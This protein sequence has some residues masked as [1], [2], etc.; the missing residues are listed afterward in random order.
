MSSKNEPD[1]LDIIRASQTLLNNITQLNTGTSGIKKTIIS[2]VGKLQQSGT[3]NPRGR[4]QIFLQDDDD[5]N[6]SKTQQQDFRTFSP[7][8]RIINPQEPSGNLNTIKRFT[9]TEISKKVTAKKI[10]DVSD[11]FEMQIIDDKLGMKLIIGGTIYHI[12]D[13]D[14]F[15]DKIFLLYPRDE[16][17]CIT[18]NKGIDWNKNKLL[19]NNHINQYLS[20]KT[21]DFKRLLQQIT[22][23]KD[24]GDQFSF[25]ETVNFDAVRKVYQLFR[26]FN[27]FKDSSLLVGYIKFLEPNIRISDTKHTI[28]NTFSNNFMPAAI[29]IK[30]LTRNKDMNFAQ[31]PMNSLFFFG[32]L[33][34]QD[35][36]KR[37]HDLHYTKLHALPLWSNNCYKWIVENIHILLND[38]PTIWQQLVKFCGDTK[39]N[40]QIFNSKLRSLLLDSRNRHISLAF[41]FIWIKL[42]Q[43]LELNKCYMKASRSLCSWITRYSELV[44]HSF[45]NLVKA[46]ESCGTI[47]FKKDKYAQVQ[48]VLKGLLR[49]IFILKQ[50]KYLLGNRLTSVQHD[51]NQT[52]ASNNKLK[53]SLQK[54]QQTVSEVTNKFNKTLKRFDNR[55]VEDDNEDNSSSKY[56]QEIKRLTALLKSRDSKIN[57]LK[58]QLS[59]SQIKAKHF[60]KEYK[61][62]LDENG[63]LNNVIGKQKVTLSKQNEEIQKYRNKLNEVDTKLSRFSQQYE[64]KLNS[65][66]KQK[67]NDY[68]QYEQQVSQYLQDIKQYKK[69]VTSL[70]NQCN[71]LQRQNDQLNIKLKNVICDRCDE[72]KNHLK[73][74]TDLLQ[75]L[76][77]QFRVYQTQTNDQIEKLKTQLVQAQTDSHLQSQSNW[78]SDPQITL[79]FDKDELISNLQ[80]DVSSL[81]DRLRSLNMFYQALYRIYLVLNAFIQQTNKNNS[82]KIQTNKQISK[83]AIDILKNNVWNIIWKTVPEHHYSLG[84][85]SLDKFKQGIMWNNVHN[86]N[87][88][89]K[90]QWSLLFP[91]SSDPYD[92]DQNRFK[93][94]T[95]MH[96]SLTFPSLFPTLSSTSKPKENLLKDENF[97]QINFNIQ[98]DSDLDLS[99]AFNEDEILNQGQK[100]PFE[101]IELK[102][103]D[104]ILI[105]P[106]KNQNRIES[107][108]HRT[109]IPDSLK[110]PSEKTKLPKLDDS[111]SDDDNNLNDLDKLIAKEKAKTD[112]D[113]LFNIGLGKDQ[114]PRREQ[115]L[116]EE[117]I[118][119]SSCPP[120]ILFSPS[121]HFSN[122]ELQIYNACAPVDYVT[123]H[124]VPAFDFNPDIPTVSLDLESH[125]LDLHTLAGNFEYQEI[126]ERVLEDAKYN[127]YGYGTK[128]HGRAH[129]FLA[130][131]FTVVTGSDVPWSKWLV[132]FGFYM[133]GNMNIWYNSKL[134]ET[135]N[136]DAQRQWYDFLYLFVQENLNENTPK[137][138]LDW[139]QHQ[140]FVGSDIF[141][142]LKLAQDA[143]YRLHILHVMVFTQFRTYFRKYKM[144]GNLEILKILINAINDKK[145][146]KHVKKSMNEIARIS[147]LNGVFEFL[148]TYYRDKQK[149][150]AVKLDYSLDYVFPTKQFYQYYFKSSREFQIKLNYQAI[151]GKDFV[152]PRLK[153]RNEWRVPYKDWQKLQ[154]LN[155]L[156]LFNNQPKIEIISGN[157]S[158]YNQQSYN[159]S[160]NWKKKSYNRNYGNNKSYNRN[161][162]WK[163]N[164]SYKKNNSNGKNQ[165]KNGKNNGNSTQQ[166]VKQD[167]QWSTNTANSN[168][169]SNN[170]NNSNKNVES[171][172]HDSSFHFRNRLTYDQPHHIHSHVFEKR[173]SKNNGRNRNKSNSKFN[174][175]NNKFNSRS[176]GRND[177]RELNKKTCNSCH[178][179]FGNHA[180]E[181]PK[182]NSNGNRPNYHKGNNNKKQ[183]NN[184]NNRSYAIHTVDINRPNPIDYF[185]EKNNIPIC[186]ICLDRH[187][188]T[189]DQKELNIKLN[190]KQIFDS[191]VLENSK[192]LNSHP[193]QILG[194]KHSIL[195]SMTIEN[196]LDSSKDKL[197]GT[198]FEKPQEVID[199]EISNLIYNPDFEYLCDNDFNLAIYRNILEYYDGEILS[200]RTLYNGTDEL[201]SESGISYT[202]GINLDSQIPK[203]SINDLENELDINLHP[204]KWLTKMIYYLQLLVTCKYAKQLYSLIISLLTLI[205]IWASKFMFN[206]SVFLTQYLISIISTIFALVS[207]LK[208]H[209][210]HK[211]IYFILLLY[212]TSLCKA[213]PAALRDNYAYLTSADPFVF[214]HAVECLSIRTV[215]TYCYIDFDK[216]ASAATDNICIANT[217]KEYT[218]KLDSGSDINIVNTYYWKKLRDYVRLGNVRYRVATA[219]GIT[220]IQNYLY[221]ELTATSGE[222]FWTKFFYAPDLNSKYGFI[223]SKQCCRLLGYEVKSSV[224]FRV[225]NEFHSDT[226]VSPA[227]WSRYDPFNTI[228]FQESWRG[229]DLHEI[230]YELI[231]SEIMFV[232]ADVKAFVREQLYL[233]W[234]L[235]GTNNRYNIARIKGFQYEFQLVENPV[236]TPVAPYQLPYSDTIDIYEQIRQLLHADMIEKVTDT[237]LHAAPTFSLRK[238]V[239]PGTPKG[240][241]SE[242]RMLHNYSQLNANILDIQDMTPNLWDCL[243]T[244][245]GHLYTSSY[246]L[247][248]AYSQLEIAE[249]CRKYVRFSVPDGS[250]YQWKVG[251]FGLKDL[252]SVWN[253]VMSNIFK[254]LGLTYY[255]DDISHGNDTIEEWQIDF[256]RFLD[257]SYEFHLT[258][259]VGKCKFC[260][261]EVQLLGHLIVKGKIHPTEEQRSKYLSIPT[262][263]GKKD[264]KRYLGVLSYCSKFISR[265]AHLSVDFYELLQKNVTFKWNLRLDKK[266]KI[267]TQA[268][269]TYQVL[270]APNYDYPFILAVDAS[271][272][273]AGCSIF[274]IYAD[275]SGERTFHFIE[276]GS[277]K[278]SQLQKNAWHSTEKEVWSV[279][280]FL[281]RYSKYFLSGKC[282]HHVYSDAE[283]LKR[284]F[285]KNQ[286]NSKMMRYRYRIAAYKIQVHHIPGELN[287]LPDFLSRHTDNLHYEQNKL[288]KLHVLN[289]IVNENIKIYE[290]ALEVQQNVYNQ[291]HIPNT[292]YSVMADTEHNPICDECHH[293]LH[294]N[295]IFNM[296]GYLNDE[297]N[298]CHKVISKSEN[299]WHCLNSSKHLNHYVI[300]EECSESKLNNWQQQ[301]YYIRNLRP[302]PYRIIHRPYINQLSFS[303]NVNIHNLELLPIEKKKRRRRKLSITLPES[304]ICP[305]KGCQHILDIGKFS[306]WYPGDGACDLCDADIQPNHTVYHCP[307]TIHY[308][309]E[310][311]DEHG[312]DI[313]VKCICKDIGMEV[314]EKYDYDMNIIPDEKSEKSEES[315][316]IEDVP[317]E[318][319]VTPSL[320]DLKLQQD[321]LIQST[322][323]KDDVKEMESKSDEKEDL[324]DISINSDPVS[325]PNIDD[326]IELHI[327][328]EEPEQSSSIGQYSKSP[329]EPKPFRPPKSSQD[330]D[331][332]DDDILT[333]SSKSNQSLVDDNIY[334]NNF[335]KTFHPF[336][337]NEF[338]RINIDVFKQ[339]QIADPIFG[340]IIQYL[341]NQRTYNSLS[342]YIKRL[343][344]N[345]TFQISNRS[346]LLTFKS[347]KNKIVRVCVPETCQATTV[348]EFHNKY[349]HLGMGKLL[350]YL[351]RK[352]YWPS[353]NK[354]IE[355]QC[356]CC[357]ICAKGKITSSPHVARF[358][359]IKPTRPNQILGMDFIGP[360]PYESEYG[361]QYILTV[362]DYFD[363]YTK[364]IPCK[365]NSAFETYLSLVNQWFFSE[366]IPEEIVVDRGSHFTASLQKTNSEMMNYSIKFT[367]SYNPRAAGLVERYNRRFRSFMRTLALDS[368]KSKH[369]FEWWQFCGVCSYINNITISKKTGLSPWQM[370]RC[371]QPLDVPHYLENI[372]KA[373]F[374]PKFAHRKYF[375]FLKKQRKLFKEVRVIGRRNWN[376]Y[377]SKRS[378][379]YFEKLT[380]RQRKLLE[381]ANLHIGRICM[382]KNVTK[383]GIVKDKLSSQYRGPFIII[384]RTVGNN[385][386]RIRNIVTDE[387]KYVNHRHIKLIDLDNDDPVLVAYKLRFPSDNRSSSENQQEDMNLHNLDGD[388]SEKK[389][390]STRKKRDKE[391]KEDDDVSLLDKQSSL[392]SLPSEK[393]KVEPSHHNENEFGD[394][395]ES[396]NDI[397]LHS[398]NY[399]SN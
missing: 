183:K 236:W 15:V 388:Y 343:L 307:A 306:K 239:P 31:F 185:P 266:W 204:T 385:A 206:K 316:I 18:F 58:K 310:N 33:S 366:G 243:Q 2:S 289:P 27:L 132:L 378:I 87:A 238:K 373:L 55:L 377:I 341:N 139:I 372:D 227:E 109:F 271:D 81:K 347:K 197:N 219:N 318:R 46:Y 220:F 367:T 135:K 176:K 370:R 371:T 311:T 100:P 247:R 303:Q 168:S 181:C 390:S 346:D 379:K 270:E 94:L 71:E 355:D 344:S 108:F 360:M 138:L 5:E 396:D 82:P 21:F 380:N 274:Q 232:N 106:D 115:K 211:F 42:Q 30:Q 352:Y 154:N 187:S 209:L 323:E 93:F 334:L 382:V 278:F 98:D 194:N 150:Y 264:L 314:P 376:K 45:N 223:L 157:K 389:R 126:K 299:A 96:K 60:D 191:D 365:N 7:I 234:E 4:T 122:E 164:N 117:P 292:L 369:D 175:R 291:I 142:F 172:S 297:C 34:S 113:L 12:N 298:K 32:G 64:N 374:E 169:N 342:P 116:I 358:Q 254:D 40:S 364:Y 86:N 308:L 54:S 200:H 272:T 101:Q 66:R 163:N 151:Y 399:N 186:P 148:T 381:K 290:P 178:S 207:K 332:D 304:Q 129:F 240:Y 349:I 13:T 89:T 244:V 38:N 231:D 11:L 284:L 59:A 49:E 146:N 336:I 196:H 210:T 368:N 119:A 97:D 348:N 143:W 330:F 6:E 35:Y 286:L 88:P 315:D 233:R 340:K 224:T 215:D 279:C 53:Q 282:R 302:D 201:R 309:D 214:G 361:L 134:S 136:V 280:Y 84:N 74:A 36:S 123:V 91:D 275:K 179:K 276:F 351:R 296:N 44:R 285:E 29:T 149:E 198:S 128:Y 24:N 222:T 137:L 111:D 324:P 190:E 354:T 259:R 363:N 50:Q 305:F 281:D 312:Y 57:D 131:F 79:Q 125:P 325:H 90:D 51:L 76:Q 180:P 326:D 331:S 320:K 41:F 208:L 253:N 95:S 333:G 359:T 317:M 337:K 152:W 339:Q 205:L 257:R 230:T 112:D 262:P 63:K 118:R 144:P 158:Y 321:N 203:E 277:K 218:F 25:W 80:V 261:Y 114:W 294:Y 202:D 3:V 43:S 268:I 77:H 241:R 287:H 182:N 228:E 141:K 26:K 160:K 249:K 124:Q 350:H 242:L 353:M 212:L 195:S 250:V 383:T 78:L 328:D 395:D 357:T 248:N 10:A 68:E 329:L 72:N 17:E 56:L 9:G 394:D 391:E 105:T 102:E 110:Q 14:K 67:Q 121:T 153:C 171:N 273:A 174:S 319:P 177:T 384:G 167:K 20:G 288:E 217:G 145:L 283:L 338:N 335:E 184:N 235:M 48:P 69:S 37:A 263:K 213:Q 8:P 83:Y 52:I 62:Q 73:T 120:L 221:L 267:L 47:F 39:W 16:S 245:S 133:Y 65:L 229:K 216:V 237:S 28:L 255:F 251:N 130:N 162:S 192:E 293:T 362:V 260:E 387:V 345:G 300:C 393:D 155:N 256:V 1:P 386:Y 103:H 189:C 173:K 147:K 398:S 188:E 313:C 159:K 252:P 99:D 375:R 107:D 269:E 85:W 193:V 75:Q 397:S 265:F 199:M 301:S 92:I 258:I 327:N 19:V 165:N 166:N 225:N 322:Q 140:P 127:M 170:S 356:R 295:T 161:N 61:K 104:K 246:D 156:D 22:Y 226:F 23:P 392:P 70:K